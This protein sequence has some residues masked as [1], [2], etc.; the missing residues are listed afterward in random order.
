METKI[1]TRRGRPPK[2]E[3]EPEQKAEPK[4]TAAAGPKPKDFLSQEQKFTED[5]QDQ[6]FAGLVIHTNAPIDQAYDRSK[7]AAHFY[8]AK[9]RARFAGD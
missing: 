8:S 9:I 7:Q 6:L 3:K 5:L 2:L 4:T 1:E